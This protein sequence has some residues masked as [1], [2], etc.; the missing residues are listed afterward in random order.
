MVMRVRLLKRKDLKRG[1]KE[2][3]NIINPVKV[4][5]ERVYNMI[6]QMNVH[7]FVVED[8]GKIIGTGTLILCY[9]FGGHL[10]LIEDVAVLDS[11]RNK[12][13]GY[14]LIQHILGFA[15]HVG[16]YK[17]ILTCRDDTVDFYIKNYMVKYQNCMCIKF[18]RYFEMKNEAEIGE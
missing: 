6:R 13:V 10:G 7:V 15:K 3:L 11:E 1:F 5:A 9:K 4:V 17:V 18:P 16:C 2:V 14:Q 12:G 8:K